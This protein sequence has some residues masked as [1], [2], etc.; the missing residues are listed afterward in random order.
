[1]GV[2]KIEGGFITFWF[3]IYLTTTGFPLIR[4]NRSCALGP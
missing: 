4:Y 1:M 3:H 2:T